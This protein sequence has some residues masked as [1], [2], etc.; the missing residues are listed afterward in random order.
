[1]ENETIGKVKLDYKHYAGKDLYCDGDVEAQILEAVKQA[2]NRANSATAGGTTAKDT[3]PGG[4]AADKQTDLTA[5]EYAD[6]IEKHPNWPFLYH[7]SP[8]R[9]NIVSWLP[10]DKSDKVLEV[11]SG[12]GAITGALSKMAGIVDCVDLSRQRSLIN[13]HR[14]ENCDNVTIHVG[15]FQDIEPDLPNDYSYICLIGVF[16]YGQAYIGGDKPYETFLSILKK[17]LATHGRI[18]IAIENKFGLKYFAGCKEDHVGKFFEGIEDYPGKSPA[19]TFTENGLLKIAEKVGFA[20]GECHMYYPYPD[21]KFMNTLF[22]KKRMPGEGELKDNLRNF[23]RDRYLLFNEKLA[24]DNI[25]REGEFSL[26]SNSYMLVL[27]RDIDTIYT[28]YSNDR[29]PE[30]CIST[31]IK[32]VRMGITGGSA[33]RTVVKKALTEDAKKHIVKIADNYKLLSRRYEGSK[34]MICPCTLSENGKEISFPYL[35]G[36]RLEEIL[37]EKLAKKDHEGFKALVKEFYERISYGETNG[38]EETGAV[39]PGV[40]P[41]TD[42]DLIFS[43]V[44]VDGDKWTVI[45]YEWVTEENKPSKE[46]AYRATYCYELEDEARRVSEELGILQMLGLSANDAE[47]IRRE[48]AEFQKKVSGGHKSLGEIR[49]DI[50]NE[51]VDLTGSGAGSTGGA[52]AQAGKLQVYYDFGNGFSEEN[53]YFADRDGAG[54]TIELKDKLRSIRLDPCDYSCVVNIKELSV[55]GTPLE[56]SGSKVISNGSRI[57]SSVF[58]FGTADPNITIGL[59]G[60]KCGEGKKMRAVFDINALPKSIAAALPEGEEKGLTTKIKRKL[61]GF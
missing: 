52:I 59:K 29:D 48:E 9:E 18:V 27:G 41:V 20:K 10:M 49:E 58:V 17:H 22:S 56:I 44:I 2:G 54:F 38:A 50:G 28:R 24:F 32:E 40:Q 46:V 53:S 39:K 14:H 5:A 6:I 8:I 11:G 3:T 36:K 31:E 51:V 25:I 7:L 45:D 19:R 21:Y 13:A 16:E 12:C 26:F 60:V 47:R 33:V 37:D 23:D 35:E 43:N 4:A 15:N 1:M 42:M 34:L 55:E 30:K 57:G 61:G